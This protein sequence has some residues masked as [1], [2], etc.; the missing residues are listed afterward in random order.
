MHIVQQII[1]IY[2]TLFYLFSQFIVLKVELLGKGIYTC[3]FW[4][5]FAKFLQ[6][7]ATYPPTNGI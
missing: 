1:L 5:H 4:K 3:L 6:N 7:C 2:F